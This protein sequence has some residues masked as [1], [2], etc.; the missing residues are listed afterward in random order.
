MGAERGLYEACTTGHRGGVLYGHL[1]SVWGW[2][3]RNP[4]VCMRQWR[5][6]F[7]TAKPQL[8]LSPDSSTSVDSLPVGCVSARCLLSS[9][10]FVF[11]NHISCCGCVLTH[12]H[13]RCCTTAGTRNSLNASGC[14]CTARG[15]TVPI[16]LGHLCAFAPSS[17]AG[18]AVVFLRR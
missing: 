17:S 12:S 2:S 10:S 13:C 5:Y 7:R 11:T 6:I 14:T 1:A 18:V 3:E 4:D 8:R 9:L 16:S 15:Q